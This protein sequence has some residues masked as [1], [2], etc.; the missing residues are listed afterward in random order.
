MS[1]FEHMVA[2]V[3]GQIGKMNM[4]TIFGESRQAGDKVIIPVGKIS[5]G[6]GGGGGKGEMKAEEKQEGE[7]SGMGMGAHIKPVGFIIVTPESV[8]YEPITDTGPLVVIFG[9]FLG[10]L[11]LSYFK[12][13]GKAMLMHKGPHACKHGGKRGLW[14]M[15]HQDKEGDK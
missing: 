11:F 10:C 4:E 2:N 8:Y 9:V 14:H 12:L 15:H 6:W 13:M 3:V 1:E 5:Y 7:G